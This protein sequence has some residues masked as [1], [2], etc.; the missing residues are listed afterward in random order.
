MA[1]SNF[2]SSSSALKSFR[3]FDIVF[4]CKCCLSDVNHITN[5]ETIISSSWPC[6]SRC[7]IFYYETKI[8]CSLRFVILRC[9]NDVCPKYFKIRFFSKTFLKEETKIR[10]NFSLDERFWYSSLCTCDSAT[11]MKNNNSTTIITFRV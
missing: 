11:K 9:T 7:V 10:K 6:L 5:E 3:C 2:R 1:S 8:S 4:T